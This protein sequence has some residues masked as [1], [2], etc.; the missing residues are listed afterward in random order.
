VFTGTCLLMAALGFVPG[1]AVAADQSVTHAVESLAFDFADRPDSEA[2][3]LYKFL[4]QAIF[5]PG[6]AISDRAAAMSFLADE[7]EGLGAPL[8]GEEPCRTLGGDPILVRVHLRPF[9]AGG[10]DPEALIDAFVATANRVHGNLSQMS[11]A[12]SLVVKWLHSDRQKQLATQLEKLGRD[13][14]KQDYPVIHHSQAYIKAY[15]PAYRVVAAE[16]AAPYGWCE[17]SLER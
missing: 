14:A 8:P 7:I 12:I 16:L 10:G 6:H 17:S 2:A 13:L 5:G 4:H 15:K 3:D 9:V 11:E 1:P